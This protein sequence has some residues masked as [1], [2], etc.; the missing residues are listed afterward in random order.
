MM[1][2]RHWLLWLAPFVAVVAGL[3]AYHARRVRLRAAGA[4]SSRLGREAAASGGWSPIVIALVAALVTIGMSGVRWGLASTA[5]QSRSLNV[6]FVI[7]VSKSMRAQDVLPDRMT[8]A[9]RVARRL[10]QDLSGDRLGLIAF[11]AN[12]YL[13]SPL[14]LDGS[15]I[16]LQLDALDPSLASQ[17]GTDIGIALGMA[18]KVLTQASEGGDRAIVLIT[19]GESFD[20]SARVNA[21]ASALKGDR[22]T[23]VT[24][25]VGTTEGAR[26]PEPGGGWHLDRSGREVI[27]RRDDALLES[28]T[29]AAAGIIIP[30]DSPDPAGSVRA[31]LNRLDRKSVRDRVAAD[32]I[33]RSWLLAL[34][35]L[36]LLGVHA[37]TRRTAALIALAICLLPAAGHAQRPA[38]GARL[39]LRGDTAAAVPTWL[40]E[41]TTRGSDTAWYNAGTAALVRG[42]LDKATEALQHAAMS[43]DPELR[44]RA[45]YNLGTTRL[46]QARTDSTST[47]RDSLASLATTNLRDALTLAPNSAAA[48]YNYELARSLL[49]P[50][51]PPNQGGGGKSSSAANSDQS[52]RQRGDM[53]KAEAEQVLGAMERSETETRR[54]LARQQQGTSSSGPDW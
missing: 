16:A 11:A 6:A 23:L 22:I 40:R 24:I 33:P 42:D 36:I 8:R 3:L 31:A 47:A 41:A 12:S 35:A 53:S 28:M 10:A 5:A 13:L 29:K 15:A 21:A 52:P 17:G 48:K 30:A 19:D 20:G 49:R 43:L 7:D 2:E 50:P 4:W 1:A 51:P 27:T 37:V 18:N 45:L 32:L 26:I 39:M 44:Q 14:T 38:A 46:I 25:P 9:V 34:A 54:K